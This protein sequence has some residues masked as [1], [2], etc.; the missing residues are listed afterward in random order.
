MSRV[1]VVTGGSRG[2]GRAVA[3]EAARRGFDVALSFRSRKDEAQAV[4]DEIDTMGRR[5]AA[6]MVDLAVPGDG[7]VVVDAARSLGEVSLLV[8]N[9][10][11]TNSCA[12]DDL[13]LD[14][15]EEAL[16][17]NLTAPAWLSKLLAPDLRRS[18][19]AIVNMGS[20]G[21]LTGSVH[22]LAYGASKAGVHGMTK[23]L[24]RMLAPDVRVNAVC[25]GPIATEMLDSLTPVQME[26]V[27]AATPV[28]RLGTPEEIAAVVLDVAGW[29]YCTGQAIVVDGG[30]VM[31]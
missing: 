15:F 12:L 7:S 22:S 14:G 20:T 13:T 18:A 25:P 8:N 31:Q 5:A 1:A 3:L 29:T 6:V 2:I 26:A 21:G 10:G 9:A 4:V 17:V 28:G 19:G 27:M 23:T 16:A 24:A 30:R 11:I